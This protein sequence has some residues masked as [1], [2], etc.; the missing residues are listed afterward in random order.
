MNNYGEPV[1]LAYSPSGEHLAVGFMEGILCIF[2]AALGGHLFTVETLWHVCIL[3]YSP[4]GGTLVF[5]CE[6]EPALFILG[7]RTYELRTTVELDCIEVSSIP[8]FQGT[9]AVSLPR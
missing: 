2:D 1:C 3:G 8:F 5:A 6:N 7:T 9:V 4:D